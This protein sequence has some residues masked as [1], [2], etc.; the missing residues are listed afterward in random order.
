MS[1]RKVFVLDTSVVVEYLDEGSPYGVERLFDS[2]AA[3]ALRA[4]VTPVTLSEVVYVAARI[5]TEAGVRDPN[6]RAR[7]L[8]EWLLALPGVEFEPVGREAAMTA[9]EL[10]KSFRLALPDLY[11]IAVGVLRGAIPLFLKPEAEMKPYEVELRKLGVAFWEEVR[12][13][14]P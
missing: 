8:A 9:G 10:R 11:V 1:W 14:L 3:G 4:Y 7:E 13:Q 2:L 12:H 6:A 5:Y